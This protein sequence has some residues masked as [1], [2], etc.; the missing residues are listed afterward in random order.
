MDSLFKRNRDT[1]LT[2]ET[3]YRST[4]Q[5]IEVANTALTNQYGISR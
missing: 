4:K 1:I 2:L 3:S 5:I